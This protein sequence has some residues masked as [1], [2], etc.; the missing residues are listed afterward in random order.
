MKTRTHSQIDSFSFTRL[1]RT[2]I[3]LPFLL[4]GLALLSG[5]VTP[6]GPA[7]IYSRLPADQSGLPDGVRPLTEQERQ[8]YDEID[9]QV[10]K[11]QNQVMAAEAAARAWARYYS[12]PTTNV[13][14]GSYY[15]GGWGGRG[16]G[17]GTGFGYG[18]APGWGW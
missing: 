13:Y 8:R 11:E 16:W 9:K 3:A 6:P 10:L 5:C 7:P 1:N 17:W 14:Y 4:G 18:Y 2:A 15:G 12:P